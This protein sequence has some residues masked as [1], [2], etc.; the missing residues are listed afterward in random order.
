MNW[1]GENDRR[2][3][4][5]FKQETK[6]IE[7]KLLLYLIH[8]SAVLSFIVCVW[9]QTRSIRE[10]SNLADILI[11]RLL[12]ITILKQNIMGNNKTL[13]I[14][15]S[16]LFLDTCLAIILAMFIMLLQLHWTSCTVTWYTKEL[17]T[18]LEINA[19]CETEIWVLWLPIV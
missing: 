15:N 16:H 1:S 7:E 12:I 14:F 11:Y 19:N 2:N 13:G 3:E 10:N 9:L 6:Y 5:C 17:K 18:C 8:L 4:Y